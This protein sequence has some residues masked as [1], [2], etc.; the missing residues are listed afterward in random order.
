MIDTINPKLKRL[1]LTGMTNSLEERLKQ[2]QKEKWS[3]SQFLDILLSDEAERRDHKRFQ[4]CLS[5]SHLDPTKSL[6]TFDFK[7]NGNIHEPLL[8]ERAGGQYLKSNESILLIG[9]SGVG[10]SHLAQALGHEALRKGHE[11]LS[12]RTY[13]LMQWIYAGN[14][15]G[16]HQ[17]RLNQV[18][19][20]SL[21]ILDDFGLQPLSQENQEDLYEIICERYEKQATIIT[22]NRDFEE[23]YSV[24]GNPLMA[25]AALDRLIHKA[26][27]VDIDG[28]SY[29]VEEFARRQKKLTRI[30]STH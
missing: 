4:M 8:R 2:A 18:V 3:Y 23:W 19:K 30:R 7:F 1:K 10:K 13:Q 12:C 17:R 5:K 9:P 28:K 29:R 25:G 15:D 20:T 16:S 22:S 27:K 14:A 24:F 26:I 21:L 6:E 11:V